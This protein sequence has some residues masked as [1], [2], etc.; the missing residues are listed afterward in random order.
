MSALTCYR[1]TSDIVT[2]FTSIFWAF[3]TV[4]AVENQVALSFASLNASVM[5]ISICF[6]LR[7]VLKTCPTV[8]GGLCPEVGSAEHSHQELLAGR[9]T[10]IHCLPHIFSRKN[11]AGW[12]TN[13]LGF[14]SP[15]HHLSRSSRSVENLPPNH[16]LA[17]LRSYLQGK[18]CPG[19]PSFWPE[20]NHRPLSFGL[21]LN[22]HSHWVT[23]IYAVYGSL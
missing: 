6:H 18:S 14:L 21:G 23:G 10:V 8:H 17:V 15:S 19:C 4:C 1:S 5:A 11:L 2:L 16:R 9:S 13:Q 3:H 20:P 12:T 22:D 7:S